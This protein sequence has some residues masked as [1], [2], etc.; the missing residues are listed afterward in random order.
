MA[1]RRLAP[2]GP[3][4]RY[5][6][7]VP[8]QYARAPQMGFEPIGIPSASMPIARFHGQVGKLPIAMQ[9]T[10]LTVT[11]GRLSSIRSPRRRD[12]GL[13]TTRSRSTAHRL[14]GRLQTAGRVASHSR[15]IDRIK[16]RISAPPIE[17]PLFSHRFFA[18]KTTVS[19]GQADLTPHRRWVRF[20]SALTATTR[21]TG[22]TVDADGS[23]WSA[24]IR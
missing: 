3:P 16:I 12:R 14:C 4:H 19:S 23:L 6:K 10:T 8:A 13:R 15:S 7:T 20:A 18:K 11:R 22:I 9:E 2:E 1:K 17:F 24:N 21:R 5:P